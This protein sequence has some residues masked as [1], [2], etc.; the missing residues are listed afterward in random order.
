MKIVGL[1]CVALGVIGL[2]IYFINLVILDKRQKRVEEVSKFFHMLG[3]MAY[4]Y[5]MRHIE[6]LTLDKIGEVYKW[7]A[8]KYTF[9]QLLYSSR[10][11]T[12]EEWYTKEELEKI[13]S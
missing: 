9:R 7:F 4:D 11:L 2:I 12:L 6:Q 8:D 3:D 13:R 10:P 5:N 1:L